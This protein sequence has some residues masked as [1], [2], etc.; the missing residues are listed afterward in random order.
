[1]WLIAQDI[2]DKGHS[3]LLE[4]GFHCSHQQ[5]TSQ[6]TGAPSSIM[7]RSTVLCF[8]FFANYL[9]LMYRNRLHSYH[10]GYSKVSCFSKIFALSVTDHPGLFWFTFMVNLNLRTT[11]GGVI[12]LHLFIICYETYFAIYF[13]TKLIYKNDTFVKIW[14]KWTVKKQFVPKMRLL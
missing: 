11:L 3:S 2:S 12:F 1:M 4:S 14:N 10:A 6:D 5:Y 8:P 9:L 13:I 7:Y